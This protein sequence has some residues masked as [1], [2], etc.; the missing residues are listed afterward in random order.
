MQRCKVYGSSLRT[1]ESPVFEATLHEFIVVE[2]EVKA[3]VYDDQG[4]LSLVDLDKL[5]FGA[6][7]HA[8]IRRGV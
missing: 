4:I 2:N 8:E 7:T 6:T 5:R 3:I 1:T